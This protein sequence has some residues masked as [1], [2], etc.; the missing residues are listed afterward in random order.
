MNILNLF[1][2]KVYNPKNEFKRYYFVI[3]DITGI[4]KLSKSK[5]DVPGHTV[6]KRVGMGT[7]GGFAVLGELFGNEHEAGSE[8]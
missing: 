6:L 4:V 8:K 7:A 2:K 1:K 5:E 3:E